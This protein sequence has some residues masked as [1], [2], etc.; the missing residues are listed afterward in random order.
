MKSMTHDL[1]KKI[2]MYI[3]NRLDISELI[4][5]VSIKGEDL[6][7][8]II[9]RLVKVNCDLSACNF[10]GAVIG[11]EGEIVQL[12]GSILR[13]CNFTDVKFIE[14]IWM[15][16]VDARGSNFNGCFMPY[17]EY[18]YS[19]MRNCKFCGTIIRLGSKEGYKAKVDGSIFEALS[20]AW[21]V[22]I[23]IKEK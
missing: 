13:D 11:K 16:K 7:R 2:K 1:R 12:S 21:N 23:E 6:S 22:N 8:A 3:K 17:L 10:S 14:K 5:D 15:R 9:I 18:Q 20:K 4:K 19:D